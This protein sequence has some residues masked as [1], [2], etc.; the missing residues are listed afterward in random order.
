MGLT[1]VQRYCAACDMVYLVSFVR[2]SKIIAKNEIFF[3]SQL[4]LVPKMG[5][6]PLEFNQIFSLMKLDSLSCHKVTIT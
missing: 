6:T 5:V 1:T 3:R 2:Y 4:Y